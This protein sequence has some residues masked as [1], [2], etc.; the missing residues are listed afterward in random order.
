MQSCEGGNIG[1]GR[2]AD[3]KGGEGFTPLLHAA[4]IGCFGGTKQ[5]A[6]EANEVIEQVFQ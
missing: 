6:H 4:G 5:A 3:V 2:F 1:G